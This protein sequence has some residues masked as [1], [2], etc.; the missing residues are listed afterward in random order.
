MLG[1]LIWV[2]EMELGFLCIQ[3]KC[4]AGRAFSLPLPRRA[5]GEST[6][7]PDIENMDVTERV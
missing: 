3:K 1:F 5:D 6:G 2:L 7:A 4:F